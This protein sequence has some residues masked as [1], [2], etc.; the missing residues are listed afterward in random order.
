ME[1]PRDIPFETLAQV[2]GT[3]WT[4]GRGELN[5][6]L[7]QIKEQFAED[8]PMI[9]ALEIE[10]RARLYRRVFEGAALTP[11]ALAKH[12][13]RVFEEMHRRSEQAT[14][15]ST[16]YTQCDTCGGHRFVVYSTRP[17]PETFWMKQHGFKSRGEIEEY[18]PC[19]ECSSAI[20]GSFRRFDG[21]KMTPPDPAQVREMLSR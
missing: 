21:T 4:V 9:L 7:A 11:S 19:P 20:D 10:E 12:W 3:D 8:D 13:T 17:M 1:R 6:A 14:N 18:A 16:P 15:V 2:T 5:K